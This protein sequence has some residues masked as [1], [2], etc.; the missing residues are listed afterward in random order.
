MSETAEQ[1]II[2]SLQKIDVKL[3]KHDESFEAIHKTLE[4]LV[5]VD[6][7]IREMKI[8]LDRVFRRIE[9]VESTQTTGCTALKNHVQVRDEKMKAYDKVIKDM[10]EKINKVETKISDIQNVPNKVLFGTT[11]AVMST[12]VSGLFGYFMFN[13][14]GK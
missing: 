13:H 9:V 11:V 4:K 6:I 7:E 5:A 8:S 1:L 12:F 14:G 2:N 10:T 3:N